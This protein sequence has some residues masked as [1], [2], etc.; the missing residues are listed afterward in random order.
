MA[1]ELLPVG[2]LGNKKILIDTGDTVAEAITEA[3][4]TVIVTGEVA[5]S[6]SA[7]QLPN[8]ACH[9]V[10]IKACTSNAGSVYLGATGSVTKADGT[11]DTTTGFELVA[12]DDTGW[13]PVA[14]LNQ[15]W[16]ICDNAGDDIT[17]MAV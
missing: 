16:R 1:D 2:Q 6:A 8:I 11:T 10:R 9:L 12:G 13:M 15:F 7:S 14:N 5:G 3:S 4:Y 17:Y